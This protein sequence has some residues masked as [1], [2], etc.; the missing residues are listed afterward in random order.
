[1]I[2]ARHMLGALRPLSVSGFSDM[3]VF[4]QEAPRSGP[5]RSLEQRHGEQVGGHSRIMQIT[6]CVHYFASGE[7][8]RASPAVAVGIAIPTGP[9]KLVIFTSAFT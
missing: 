8:S 9:V 1:M 3:L 7:R 2:E 4:Y 6:L 5:Q